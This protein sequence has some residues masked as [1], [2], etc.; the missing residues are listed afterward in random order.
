MTCV[1]DQDLGDG[2]RYHQIG[3]LYSHILCND[4]MIKLFYSSE[5]VAKTIY[6]TFLKAHFKFY[7]CKTF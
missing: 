1:L 4:F 6:Q 2:D 3:T 5:I 7:I